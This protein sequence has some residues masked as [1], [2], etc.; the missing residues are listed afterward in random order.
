MVKS[1]SASARVSIILYERNR[2][3][4]NP[5]VIVVILTSSQR[6]KDRGA[7][8]VCDRDLHVGEA[9]EQPSYG[10]FHKQ[11]KH[12][13]TAMQ[14]KEA[15]ATVSRAKITCKLPLK[16]SDSWSSEKSTC[17]L[18]PARVVTLEVQLFR[19]TGCLTSN[20]YA[21]TRFGY[22]TIGPTITNLRERY[23]S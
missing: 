16:K 13:A 14:H 22:G 5:S 2:V 19:L 20:S 10:C 21:R 18:R 7:V 17:S 23:K 11:I 12:D 1:I 9:N 15:N 6:I 3:P 8:I 4:L